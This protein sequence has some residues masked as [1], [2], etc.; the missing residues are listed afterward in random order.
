MFSRDMT[1]NAHLMIEQHLKDWNKENLIA[2]DGTLGNGYD[3][4]FLNGLKQIDTIYGFDIQQKAIE[5]SKERIGNSV[6]TIYFIQDSHHNLESYIKQSI[7]LAIFNLGYLPG[8][9]KS[10]VTQTQTTLC[11][12]EKTIDKLTDGGLLIVMTYPGHEEGAR[13]HKE[14]VTYLSSLHR[15]NLAILQLNVNNVQKPCPN[16]F[17]IVNKFNKN[18]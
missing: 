3:L 1:K 7:D 18:K 13:E 6:K 4:E 8:A 15:K 11:A 2:M 14:I 17:I 10:V 12:I 9:D 5:S 16:C